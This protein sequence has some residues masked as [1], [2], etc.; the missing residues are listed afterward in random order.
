MKFE[1]KKKHFT[2]I[3]KQFINRAITQ[4][5]NSPIFSEPLTYFEAFIFF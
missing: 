1:N 4:I 5:F 2:K 3:C